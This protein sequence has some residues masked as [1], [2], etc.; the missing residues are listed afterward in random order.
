[1]LKRIP[2]MGMRMREKLIS[3]ENYV[4][5]DIGKSWHGISFVSST[6]L[7]LFII[8]KEK[9]RQRKRKK[10]KTK[11]KKKIKRV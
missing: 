3:E 6:F 2:G 7:I 8:P 11:T 1:M 5:R 10:T 4:F 9:K